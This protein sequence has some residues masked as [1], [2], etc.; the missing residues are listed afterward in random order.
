MAAERSIFTAIFIGGAQQ[1]VV[2]AGGT[3]LRLTWAIGG[4]LLVAESFAVH[5]LEASTL[6]WLG[7]LVNVSASVIVHD[8]GFGECWLWWRPA[9]PVAN[10]L[11][12]PRSEPDRVRDARAMVAKAYGQLPLSFEMNQGQADASMNLLARGRGYALYLTGNEAAMSLA[13]N[14]K[15]ELRNQ[16]PRRR[17][18]RMEIDFGEETPPAVLESRLRGPL[19]G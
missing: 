5:S 12:N 11:G 17:H 8:S 3:A 19:S 16:T 14:S 18:E 2:L 6:A 10:H 7:A 4:S 9:T 15:S 13:G 1:G